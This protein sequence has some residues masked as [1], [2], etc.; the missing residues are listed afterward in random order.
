M[1]DIYD[2][3]PKDVWILIIL[4]LPCKFIYNLYDVTY[5]FKE[6]CDEENII[7]TRKLKG[8]PRKSDHCKS[9][10]VYDYKG[11]VYN[12]NGDIIDNACLKVIMK[13]IRSNVYLVKL[14]LND[15]LDRLYEDNT[16]LICGDLVNFEI[17]D[18]STFLFDGEKIVDTY[19]GRNII[20]PYNLDI[21]N[22]NTQL[23]YWKGTQLENF[24]FYFDHLKIKD[25]L[26]NNIICNYKFGNIHHTHFL[27]NNKKYVIMFS[28]ILSILQIK[29][30]I[31][32][33]KFFLLENNV[34]GQD[35]NMFCCVN[36]IIRETEL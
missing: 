4:Q 32:E 29:E 35:N 31:K 28:R 20:F 11:N 8:Y 1:N 36:D 27:S 10:G 34:F 18:K 9:Y 14:T 30:K 13:N 22:N 2:I 15:T 19:I 17:G 7:Q 21:I 26:M 6:L 5:K 23:S 25:E 24:K 3:F 16:D 33:D 12:N